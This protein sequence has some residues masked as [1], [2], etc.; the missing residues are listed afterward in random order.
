MKESTWR[1]ICTGTKNASNVTVQNV[2]VPPPPNDTYIFFCFNLYC[3]C[4]RYVPQV[5]FHCSKIGGKFWIRVFQ[6]S[7]VKCRNFLWNYLP[8]QNE[9]FFFTSLYI[10]YYRWWSRYVYIPSGIW[11]WGKS[12]IFTKFS[13]FDKWDIFINL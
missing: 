1:H 8:S 11:I 7:F 9:I 10:K 4:S 13:T 12:W 2:I 6:E 3:N 5:F